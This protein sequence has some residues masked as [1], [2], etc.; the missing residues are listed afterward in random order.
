MDTV[1]KKPKPLSKEEKE[2]QKILKDMQKGTLSALNTF[3][4]ET[5]GRFDVTIDSKS[6]GKKTTFT[7]THKPIPPAKATGVK[8]TPAKAVAKK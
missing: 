4:K 6:D 5:K 8:K 2:N 3:K 7:V 1:E